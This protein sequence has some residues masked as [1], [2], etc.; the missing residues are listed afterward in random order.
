MFDFLYSTAAR[1]LPAAPDPVWLFLTLICCGLCCFLQLKSFHNELL[2]ELEKKVEL[3]ARY[4]NVRLHTS[5]LPRVC[6]FGTI[7][8]R[9]RPE[10]NPA[11]LGGRASVPQTRIGFI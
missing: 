4:L 10:P 9:V 8:E 3:D 1:P 6:V 5:F 7:M 11:V 2:T